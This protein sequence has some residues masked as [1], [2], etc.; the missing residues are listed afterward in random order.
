MNK[1]N[2]IILICILSFAFIFLAY[3]SYIKTL[4]IQAKIKI[5]EEKTK[6][7]ILKNQKQEQ[8]KKNEVLQK[9]NKE[10][11]KQTRNYKA[12]LLKKMKNIKETD[13]CC[14]TTEMYEQTN[15]AYQA[16]DKELNKVYKLLMSEL[17]ENEKIK[18]RNDE[19][20]WLKIM[21]N[22]IK[23]MLTEDYLC[24]LNS[25]GEIINFC[26]T[27]PILFKIG[28]EL[29]MTKARTLV[30]AEMYDKLEK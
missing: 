1:K 12:N 21:D 13:F 23:K 15:Y 7:E 30:L 24:E 27:E 4:E 28:I 16:W 20:A 8:D 5:E 3:N 19:R 11:I 18:L 6:Q 2:I 17:P 26:G 22:K 14:T 29:E 25:K 10:K 9:E